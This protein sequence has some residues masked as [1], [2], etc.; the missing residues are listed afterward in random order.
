MVIW[1]PVVDLKRRLQEATRAAHVTRAA[2]S[3]EEDL[4]EGWHNPVQ[5][6]RECNGR[7]GIERALNVQQDT[8]IR[9]SF[10]PLNMYVDDS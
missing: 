4:E 5:Q 1:R 9:S 3:D 2:R 7:S 10:R 6:E 8:Y